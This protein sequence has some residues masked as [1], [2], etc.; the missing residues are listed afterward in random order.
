LLEKQPKWRECGVIEDWIMLLETLLEWE[1][2][3][4][5]TKMMK[6]DAHKAKTE[7]WHIMC[8]MRKV[9][10]RTSG[11]GLKLM[12]FYGILHMAESNSQFRCSP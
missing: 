3:L 7:H 1:A 9:A 2:W 12:K 8:L 10:A 11:M 5:S 4:N 6:S